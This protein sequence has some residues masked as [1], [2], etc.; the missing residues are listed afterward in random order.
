MKSSTSATQKIGSGIF[1]IGVAYM[2]GLGWSYSWRMVPAANQFG[3]A[4]YSDLLGFIW[5]LS[6]PLGS[7]IV[8]I[9][10]ALMARAGRRVVG[11][12][13]LLLVLSV[14]WT[15]A[16]TADHV[17]PALFG[18]G[19]GLITV[20]F[21]GSTWQWAR[22]RPTLTPAGKTGSD[23]RMISSIFFV[24]SAWQLCGIFGIGN[25]VLTPELAA[26]FSV[27]IASTITSASG[28]MVLL[29]LGWGFNFLGQ[30]VSRQAAAVHNLDKVQSSAIRLLARPAHNNSSGRLAY[31]AL[32]NST[33][34]GREN[35]NE[36]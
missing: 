24:V 33:N 5:G 28:V 8:A 35:E 4:A 34:Q 2:F 6:V 23:L 27:P 22:T 9:G 25:Y 13:V 14:A 36:R 19:G 26:R 21:L 29:V 3:R 31:S 15:M 17:I 32:H 10:A 16:G 18:V 1:A 30:L 7:F 12:L 20:F 11:L